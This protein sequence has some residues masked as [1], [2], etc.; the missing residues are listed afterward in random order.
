VTEAGGGKDDERVADLGCGT[1]RFIGCLKEAFG[2]PIIETLSAG[3]P[4]HEQVDV[5]VFRR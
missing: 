1:G 2:A 4:I 3:Q 5:F